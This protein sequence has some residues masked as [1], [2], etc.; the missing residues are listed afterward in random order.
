MFRYQMDGIEEV[1]NKQR[2]LANGSNSHDVVV[3]TLTKLLK[4]NMHIRIRS[5]VTKYFG[6]QNDRFS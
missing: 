5:T 2:P 4:S 3:Y 6:K 1:Q